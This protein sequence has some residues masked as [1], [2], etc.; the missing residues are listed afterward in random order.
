MLESRIKEFYSETVF[1]KKGF[2]LDEKISRLLCANAHVIL[3][4]DAILICSLGAHPYFKDKL[5]ASE[6]M[7]WVPP[8]KR[9]TS[10]GAR[11]FKR[12]EQWARDNGAQV[13]LADC[14]DNR[15]ANFYQKLG[16]TETQRTFM[17]ELS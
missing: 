12:Y 3:E 1:A 13:I 10:L 14:L 2:E 6:L 17:K 8:D 5:V 9:G 11:L 7:W 16:Y 4:D 15:V